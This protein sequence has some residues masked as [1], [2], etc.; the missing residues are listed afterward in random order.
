MKGI[1]IFIVVAFHT[2]TFDGNNIRGGEIW[3]YAFPRFIIPF[4]FIVTGF[5]FGNK[6]KNHSNPKDYFKSYILILIKFFI[7]WHVLYIVY[8]VSIRVFYAVY[9]GEGIRAELV[10]YINIMPKLSTIYYGVGVTS[11]H[12]WYLSALIWSIGVI[13]LFVKWRKFN[14]LLIISLILNV[15]GLFGQTYTDIFYLPIDTRDALFFGLFYT[16]LGCYIA[17][18]YNRIESFIEYTSSRA[19]IAIFILSS[20]FQI[21]EG[22]VTVGIY[23]G[24][25]GGAGYYI[26]TIPLTVSLFLLLLKNKD[27][28]KRSLFTL[29]G[30]N[31]FGVYL[32]HMLFIS[33]M[34]LTLHFFNLAWLRS[35]FV[36]NL[37]FTVLIIV[38]SHIFFILIRSILLKVTGSFKRTFSNQRKGSRSMMKRRYEYPNFWRY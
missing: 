4:F 14:L 16:S 1:A 13:F 19:L 26:S 38:L 7:G 32:V 28:G 25:T 20:F 29:L 8:D 3:L 37:A 17:F 10:N 36:I 34:V 15:I 31:V 33:V 21:A 18:H 27:L 23:D 30:R 6:I 12:L 5:L 11:Y 2:I 22:F 35:Y 9:K 24:A